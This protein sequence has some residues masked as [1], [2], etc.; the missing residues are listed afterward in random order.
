M[1]LD[2]KSGDM[3]SARSWDTKLQETWATKLAAHGHARAAKVQ[4]H[5][6]AHEVLG[7]EAH[8]VAV[9]GHEAAQG[10]RAEALGHEAGHE[11]QGPEETWAAWLWRRSR[12]SC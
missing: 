10:P 4:G 6:T 12:S 11:V 5:E 9:L 3:K 2:T 1:G 7:T 8:A